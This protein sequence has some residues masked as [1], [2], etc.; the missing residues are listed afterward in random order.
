MKRV[1]W[2]ALPLIFLL[3]MYVGLDA[4]ESHENDARWAEISAQTEL[5]CNRLHDEQAETLLAR[6]D[7]FRKLLESGRSDE[8]IERDSRTGGWRLYRSDYESVRYTFQDPA[9]EELMN[10]LLE[11][12]HVE[13]VHITPERVTFMIWNDSLFYSEAAL[14]ASEQLHDYG[15]GWYH[16]AFPYASLRS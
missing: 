4:V 10:L 1:F 2:A 6:L 5:F 11:E 3:V 12:Y 13:R 14:P 9:L 7:D 16:D 15:D 8:T